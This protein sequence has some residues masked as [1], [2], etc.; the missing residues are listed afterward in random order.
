MT[1][2]SGLIGDEDLVVTSRYKYLGVTFTE[3]LDFEETAEVLSDASKRA[4]GA[5]IAKYK[6]LENMGFKTFTTLYNTGV[7]SILNYCSEVWGF[8]RLSKCDTVQ[9][10][11]LR[12]FLGVHRFAPNMGLYGDTGWLS[13]RSLRWQNMLRY[14]NRL[15]SMPE[16]RLAKQVFLWE[17]TQS[18]NNWSKEISNICQELGLNIFQDRLPCDLAELPKS[19]C[20]YEKGLWATNV[21]KKAKLRTYCKIKDDLGCESYVS[22]NLSRS[23]RALIAQLRLGILP[24][25]IETGRY[26]GLAI[27]DRVCPLCD[28]GVVEDE[29]HFI[30]SCPSYQHLRDSL[31]VVLP[32]TVEHL[33]NIEILKEL[34]VNH[35]RPLAKYVD[36]AFNHRKSCLYK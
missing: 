21:T 16:T 36:L 11:A 17:L 28:T 12:V 33:S 10:R 32:Q 15:L 4:L 7:L 18:N 23:Q 30:F 8:G 20:R 14:W 35:V 25:S 1:L 2:Y 9:N 31:M 5:I 29:L 19:L 3:H 26:K 6:V 34:F 27:S 24:L 22:M 13:C